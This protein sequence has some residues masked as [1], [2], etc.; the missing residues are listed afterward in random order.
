MY[1]LV[2]NGHHD[3]MGPAREF[4][5][6]QRQTMSM[7]LF[8]LARIPADTFHSQSLVY[9]HIGRGAKIISQL[10]PTSRLLSD[11]TKATQE[12]STAKSQS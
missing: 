8:G 9:I 1:Q 6:L 4:T 7:E 12:E 10:L 5:H 3:C 11:G 2:S